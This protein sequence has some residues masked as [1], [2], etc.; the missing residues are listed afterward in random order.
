MAEA[1]RILR[2][3]QPRR[4][5]RNAEMQ[6]P[7]VSDREP[8]AV[9][10]PWGH[11]D[12]WIENI[13][14]NGRD[15]TVHAIPNPQFRSVQTPAPAMH[16]PASQAAIAIVAAIHLD[17]LGLCINFEIEGISPA[18][19]PKTAPDFRGVLPCHL[20]GAVR[21]GA[22]LV[23]APRA[24]TIAGRPA[25]YDDAVT[26]EGQFEGQ[27]VCVAVAR[28]IVR[29]NRRDVE[30]QR[31]IGSVHADVAALLIVTNDRLRSRHR[32]RKRA[33]G[34]AETRCICLKVGETRC[35]TRRS[36]I[37]MADF[38]IGVR[39]GVQP[40]EHTVDHLAPAFDHL[41]RDPS[42]R[43]PRRIDQIQKVF[44]KNGVIHGAE[45]EIAPVCQKLIG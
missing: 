28:Q 8:E 19:D 44:E 41:G 16:R 35:D 17:R 36:I 42:V 27:A 29:P 10:F 13:A 45:F 22:T 4:A 33:G 20:Y 34:D 26:E 38:T 21:A 6:L 9:W 14:R 23:F 24:V 43:P 12:F 31:S 3:L 40:A 25:V 15:A 32:R 30:Q 2:I 1:T 18:R 39:H 11:H 7:T 37:E 5:L